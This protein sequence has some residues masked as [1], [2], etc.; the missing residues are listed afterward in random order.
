[1]KLYRLT[2]EEKY[3]S[4]MC[5][6]ARFIPQTASCPTAPMCTTDGKRMNDGEICERVN[7]SDWE[8]THGVGDSIFGSASWPEVSAMMNYLEV[9]G[10]YVTADTK[11]VYVSDHVNA[12]VKDGILHIE[13]PTAYA[14]RVKLLIEQE[15]SLSVPLGLYWQNRMQTV[16]IP[17]G[18][19]ISLSL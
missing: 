5:D 3:L 8:G 13:N 14:A 2:G 4:V 10:V 7:M 18:K 19:S 15:A 6:I 1:L 16:S 11:K 17:A 12:Y 9:P